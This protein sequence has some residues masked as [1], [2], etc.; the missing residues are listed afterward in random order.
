MGRS[1]VVEASGHGSNFVRDNPIKLLTYKD[2][3]RDADHWANYADTIGG[4][5][6]VVHVQT[7]TVVYNA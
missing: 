4:Q 2:A 5:A 6:R 1:F 3:K 7:N